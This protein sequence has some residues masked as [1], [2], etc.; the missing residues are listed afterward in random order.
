MPKRTWILTAAFSAVALAAAAGGALVWAWKFEPGFYQTALQLPQPQAREL[1]DKLLERLGALTGSMQ[2][3]GPWQALVSGDEVNGWLATDFAE[4]LSEALP[5]G[6]SDPRVQIDGDRV[7]LGCRYGAG[8]GATILHVE[9][10]PFQ[11]A[12]NAVGLRVHAVKAGAVPAPLGSLLE[13][14]TVAAQRAGCHLAWEQSGACPTAILRT[15]LRQNNG[16]RQQIEAVSLVDGKLYLAGRTIRPSKS[17]TAPSDSE[18]SPADK[19]STDVANQ[20]SRNDARQ[21]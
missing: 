15:D 21:R 18:P 3:S 13:G 8:W 4:N 16:A 5:Q 19:S 17:D 9:V 20:N 11:V 7:R 1:S 14:I 6:M 10:E 2:R 12:R